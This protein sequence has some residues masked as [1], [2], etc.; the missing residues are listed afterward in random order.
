MKSETKKIIGF[1]AVP[2]VILLLLALTPRDTERTEQFDGFTITTYRRHY[3][4][5]IEDGGIGQYV[6]EKVCLAESN[7]CFKS[8]WVLRDYPKQFEAAPW[9]RICDS[10]TEKWRFFDRTS[11]NEIFC[12]NCDA[13]AMLCPNGPQTGTW[14]DNGN[15]S[16]ELVGYA[17]E[18]LSTIRTFTY[19]TAGVTMREFPS[20]KGVVYG[21]GEVISEWF[22][23]DQSAMVWIQCDER[24]CDIYRVD[25]KTGQSTK[26][27]T[28][29]RYSDLLTFVLV[30]DRPE[31]RIDS[32]A[33]NDE[34][35]RDAQGKPAYPLGPEPAPWNPPTTDEDANKA[36][37]EMR[38][39][40]VK[41]R[42]N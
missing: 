1:F 21:A 31:I 34:I 42:A 28:P 4:L 29:C 10:K 32:E 7:L 41:G 6:G 19:D 15:K 36:T 22:Y 8:K 37:I 18:N 25:F 24:K 38:P 39:L 35:C 40:P 27:A 3:P 17:K 2:L 20:L 23:G 9:M 14:F 13:V 12:R 33:K 5:D 26:E 11:P 30:G 16:A